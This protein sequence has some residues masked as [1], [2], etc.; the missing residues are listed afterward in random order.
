MNEAIAVL[1]VEDDTSIQSIVED[2]LSDGG[3][4]QA[5]KP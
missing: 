1:V 4:L 2:T 5:R 3:F